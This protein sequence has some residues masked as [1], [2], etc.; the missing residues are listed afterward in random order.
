MYL[1]GTPFKHCVYVFENPY[2]RARDL[3]IKALF[4]SLLHMDTQNSIMYW[5]SRYLLVAAC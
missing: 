5:R 2:N 4:L 1:C 3:L